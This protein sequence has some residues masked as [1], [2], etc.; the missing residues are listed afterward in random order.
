MFAVY[1]P[2]VGIIIG[3]GENSISIRKIQS[4]PIHDSALRIADP[5]A[6]Y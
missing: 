3:N 2:H 4:P 6:P 1:F 5:A